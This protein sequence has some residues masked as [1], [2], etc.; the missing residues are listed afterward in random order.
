MKYF[1]NFADHFI[2]TPLPC[3]NEKVKKMLYTEKS[4]S[5]NGGFI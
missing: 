1:T 5:L 4:Y 3:N 2:L